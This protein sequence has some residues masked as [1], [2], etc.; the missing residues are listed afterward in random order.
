LHA[1]EKLIGPINCKIGFPIALV[2]YNVLQIAFRLVSESTGNGQSHN[3]SEPS[4][5]YTPVTNASKFRLHR[6]IRPSTSFNLPLWDGTG[7]FSWKCS[8]VGA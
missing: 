8:R 7:A 6:R 2:L 5:F 1:Q 4:A 3:S